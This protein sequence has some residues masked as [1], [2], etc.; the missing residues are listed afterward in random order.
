MTGKGSIM[1]RRDGVV[2]VQTI[3]VGR[4]ELSERV[5]YIRTGG[6]MAVGP[7]SELS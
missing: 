4:R 7:L 5:G 2:A 6:G 1:R 3:E